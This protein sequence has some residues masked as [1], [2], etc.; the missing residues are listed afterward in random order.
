LDELAAFREGRTAG[1]R[2]LGP[3]FVVL[4]AVFGAGSAWTLWAQQQVGAIKGGLTL[5]PTLNL[6]FDAMLAYAGKAFV[7]A[8]MSASYTWNEYPYISVK[9][10]L[11]SCFSKH[12]YAKASG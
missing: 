7:P 11:G 4:S 3:P 12:A 2:V 8:Y 1:T 5:L 6:T 9:G 10:M